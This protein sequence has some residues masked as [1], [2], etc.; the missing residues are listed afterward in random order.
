MTLNDLERPF[1]RTTTKCIAD[2]LFLCV[3]ELLF[4]VNGV[5]VILVMC[6]FR[7]DLETDVARRPIIAHSAAARVITGAHW[8]V[9]YTHLTLPTNREV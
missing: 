5:I 3:A 7:D 9:S 1:N 8:S 4:I 2:A 6:V